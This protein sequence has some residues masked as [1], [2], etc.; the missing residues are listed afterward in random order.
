MVALLT[1]AC[2]GSEQECDAEYDVATVSGQFN[3]VHIVVQPLNDREY[4]THV[5]AKAGLPPF[6]PLRGTQ[7]IASAVIAECVRLTCLNANLACQTFHQDLVG[8]SMNCEERL[9]QIKQ[10]G[11][12]LAS[13]ND[14]K[15]DVA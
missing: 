8:F 14:W 10:L 4:R 6:G 1:L 15:L 7:V 13:G 11:M 9:K 2:V 5:H 12:R 3:D